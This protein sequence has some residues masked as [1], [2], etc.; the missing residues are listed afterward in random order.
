MKKLMKATGITL[1]ALF[2]QTFISFI[3]N[4][5]Y[6]KELDLKSL[7][8]IF[9]YTSFIYFIPFFI[10]TIIYLFICR[11]CD[12]NNSLRFLTIKLALTAAMLFIPYTILLLYNKYF[13]D[14]SIKD[15]SDLFNYSSQYYSYFLFGLAVFFIEIIYN[16]YHIKKIGS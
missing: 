6:A 1:L 2:I 13:R 3:L 9:I 12:L 5:F 14:V 15:L 8:L 7:F 4:I 10:Y 16:V 11:K